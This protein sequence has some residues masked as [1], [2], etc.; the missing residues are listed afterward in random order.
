MNPAGLFV[1]T[2]FNVLKDNNFGYAYSDV[3]AIEFTANEEDLDTPVWNNQDSFF[4]QNTN[5]EPFNHRWERQQQ[6]VHYKMSARLNSP[7]IANSN[8]PAMAEKVFDNSEHQALFYGDLNPNQ[9]KRFWVRKYVNGRLMP[10]IPMTRKEFL[11][12][13]SGKASSFKSWKLYKPNE[14]W[15]GSED[16]RDRYIQKS[17]RKGNNGQ[18]AY[19]LAQTLES[20]G[21]GNDIP[22]QTVM[23]TIDTMEKFLFP[24]QLIQAI[25]IDKYREFVDK[26][27][28]E[29]K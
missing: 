5:P 11:S 9:I 19:E 4:G 6:K 29:N 18:Q 1:T 26:F 23:R 7:H 24:K 15:R 28:P 27:Y 3:V 14:D 25:G 12:E 10:Y 21:Y 2:D 17:P 8:N 16:F 13:Y 20:I 22:G